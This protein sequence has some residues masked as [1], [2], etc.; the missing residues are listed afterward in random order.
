MPLVPLTTTLEGPIKGTKVGASSGR[1]CALTVRNTKSC[2]PSCTAVPARGRQ[3]RV[4]PARDTLKPLLRKASSV[5]PR[6]SIDTGHPA[7]SN[8]SASQ[9]PMAPAPTM[10]TVELMAWDNTS[11]L[12]T[13]GRCIGLLL[14]IRKRARVVIQNLDTIYN[15]LY[16]RNI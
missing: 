6:A 12:A 11:A 2:A 1:I 14:A 7:R 10:A 16:I 8:A 3:W 4:F 5:A 15:L 13:G 9:A